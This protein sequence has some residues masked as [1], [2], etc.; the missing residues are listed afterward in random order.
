PPAR[1]DA[2]YESDAFEDGFE[3]PAGAGPRRPPFNPFGQDVAFSRSLTELGDQ[4]AGIDGP[5]F[6]L[7]GGLDGTLL[8]RFHWQA[9]YSFGQSE[10]TINRLNVANLDNVLNTITPGA[11]ADEPGCTYVDYFGPNGI[12]R[13]GVDY[14]RY[15]DVDHA[16]YNQ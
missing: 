10:T 3:I 9:Y 8:D 5:P 16:G 15:N 6:H 2:N 11:C 14:I 7:V 12:T 4:Q 1:L 13:R